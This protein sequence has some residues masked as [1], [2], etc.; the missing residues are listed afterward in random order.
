M[1]QQTTFK[2]PWWRPAGRTLRRVFIHLM[3]PRG[4][5]A[6]VFAVIAGLLAWQFE[7]SSD[8]GQVAIVVLG[9]CVSVWLLPE[10]PHRL[11]NVTDRDLADTVP[12]SKLRD[13]LRTVATAV[14]LQE[15]SASDA[16][17]LDHLWHQAISDLDAARRDASR[18]VRDV[19]YSIRISPREE[20]PPWIKTT[21]AAT[22]CIPRATESVWFSFCSS[23]EALDEEFRR[24]SEGCISRELADL[25]PSEQGDLD[26]W[27]ERVETYARDV[28]FDLDSERQKPIRIYAWPE[29]KG[30][31]DVNW[32]V[33]RVEF[34]AGQIAHRPVPTMLTIEFEADP[35]QRRYPVKFS[36]Y[37]VLGPTQVTFEVLST[38]AVVEKDEY[39]SAATRPLEIH[40]DEGHSGNGYSIR[41]SENTV[42]P[43]GSGAVFTWLNAPRL[44]QIGDA[45]APL[46]DTYPPIDE[47]PEGRELPAAVELPAERPRCFDV[48]ESLVPLDELADP[49]RLTARDVYASLNILPGRGLVARRGVIERLRQAAEAL[50]PDFG[51]VVLDA[52]R[53]LNEQRA[54]GEFYDRDGLMEEYVAQVREDAI[55]PPHTTGGAV[56]LTLSWHGEALALGTDFDSFSPEAHL[57]AFEGVDSV[58]RRLRRLLAAVMVDAGFAP[59]RYEWWHWSYGEDVWAATY[60]TD[61]LYDIIDRPEPVGGDH[62]DPQ[63]GG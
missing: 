8:V 42:L 50:P 2:E 37:W 46:R 19:N 59:Y 40:Y 22:R 36:A 52:H 31:E 25:R 33:V 10:E 12:P 47:L 49:E 3:R 23:Q 4:R 43:P 39:F 63:G 24:H 57:D 48:G 58:V 13:T 53:T 27:Q 21:I 34:P 35:G 29:G 15:G 14:D 60:G 62:D 61:P 6:L 20:E 44:D 54:L 32:R 11:W 51:L 55:R 45:G 5:W 38:E 16:I 9:I 41:A 1:Q 56:D 28:I 7:P 17:D 18:I 26:K 30:A